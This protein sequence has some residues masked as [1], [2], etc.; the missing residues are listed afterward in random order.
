M[1]AS[2]PLLPST[3]ILVNPH[4]VVWYMYSVIQGGVA[5]TPLAKVYVYLGARGVAQIPPRQSRRK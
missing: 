1:Q 5:Q 4:R 3:L 2:T